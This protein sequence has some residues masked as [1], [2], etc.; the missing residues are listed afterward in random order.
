MPL[1]WSQFLGPLGLLSVCV[2]LITIKP[3]SERLSV[4]FRQQSAIYKL[5]AVL[6]A[7]ILVAVLFI[8]LSYGSPS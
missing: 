1:L 6:P 8:A 5:A 7:V 3:A 4:R 2:G